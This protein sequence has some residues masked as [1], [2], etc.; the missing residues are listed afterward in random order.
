MNAKP[1]AK[2]IEDLR[3]IQAGE[4]VPYSRQVALWRKGLVDAENKLTQAGAKALSSQS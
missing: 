4:E 1:T 2:Q 3:K